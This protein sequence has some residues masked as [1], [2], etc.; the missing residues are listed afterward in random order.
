MSQRSLNEIS[1]R[2]PPPPPDFIHW[3]SFQHQQQVED[4]SKLSSPRAEGAET[5]K[6]SDQTE[7]GGAKQ[8]S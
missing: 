5:G 4:S 6:Q 7:D 3:L 8:S 1:K 2:I